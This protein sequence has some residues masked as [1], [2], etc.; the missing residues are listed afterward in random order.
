MKMPQQISSSFLE[1]LFQNVSDAI[2]VIDRDGMIR[3]VNRSF[4][5][6]SGYTVD[7][8]IGN[9]N[10]CDVCIGMATCSEEMTCVECFAKRQKMPAFQM[11]VRTKGGE[12]L[13]VAA[14]STRLPIADDEALVLILR[15]ITEQ[16]RVERERHQRQLTNYVIQAQEEER[17]RISRDLHDGIGQALYSI[18]VGLRVVNQ[19]QLDEPV[20]AHLDE[21]QQ[22]TSRTL[23]EVK[24]LSVELRPSALDDLGLVPAIRSYIK[25]FDETFGIESELTIA[26]QRRRYS[27]AVETALYRIL[28]EAMTNAA[29]YADTDQLFVT[30][31]DRE[32]ALEL[33]IVDKGVGFD[34]EHLRVK[35]TGLGLFG[36]RERASLL[37]GTVRIDSVEGVGTRIEVSIPLDEK[38]GPKYVHSF[39]DRG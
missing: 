37:G 4:E 29:K 13:P 9:I 17:K 27:S 23:E 30:L 38:G 19:L 39:V 25:R 10:L 3:A 1:S 28:Q 21:V 35:G 8:L 32:N 26:G 15:D 5:T 7:E 36:M 33:R 6:L 16:Q 2:L 18:M 14:S 22:L 31:T 12:E 20:K 11:F 24:S 34:P